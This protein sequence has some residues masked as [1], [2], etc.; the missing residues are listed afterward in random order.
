MKTLTI[1]AVL[2][3]CFLM[4][5]VKR[6]Y[7]AGILMLND[8]FFTLVRIPNFP[9][10]SGFTI[11]VICFL[12]SEL[13]HAKE[14]Y[15]KSKGTIV[16]KLTGLLILIA[17]I[18]IIFSPHLRTFNNIRLFINSELILTNFA[19]IYAFW[20]FKGEDDIKPFLNITF[21]GLI[22]LTGIG[23]VNYIT[24]HSD[25]VSTM[26][27]GLE[28]TGI[29]VAGDEAGERF[30]DS[31]RFR[32]QAT[33]VNPFD[34]GYICI[35][36][37]LLHIYGYYKKYERLLRLLIVVACTAFGIFTCG[38][39]TVIFCAMI[40]ISAYFLLAFK[41]KRAMRISLIAIFLLGISYQFIPYIQ[42][43]I[44]NSFTMFDKRSNFAGSSIEMR[45]IQYAA[46]MYHIQDSPIVGNG[47]GYFNID[48][49]WGEGRRYI[50]DERL[51]GL[52]GV[53]MSKLLE[54][55][56]LG[57]ALYVLFY[58]SL[59]VYLFKKMKTSKMPAA[60]GLSLLAAYLAFSNMT[61]ELRS[62]YPTLLI[63][64]FC[65]KALETKRS[66]VNVHFNNQVHTV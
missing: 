11:I 29:G 3:C 50:V 40:G 44:D 47:Y 22:V 31:D 26:M 20:C 48:L 35:V 49:G 5:V 18:T 25:F 30:T 21:W 8:M 24:K 38:A 1:L 37:L 66:S 41:F 51:Q 54:R 64:G 45:T 6:P 56:F 19:L 43:Q 33:F 10:K 32:V 62:V 63:V 2:V 14:L 17:I 34:Y 39:R 52:E 16:W 7:K 9:I 12:L 60:L 36:I 59:I 53:V 28:H 61:G 57:L 42:E 13:I 58:V 27:A 4:F 65:V 15:H 23:V 46:V 55:G